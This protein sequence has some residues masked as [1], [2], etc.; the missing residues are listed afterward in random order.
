LASVAKPLV[1]L[2]RGRERGEKRIGV[3]PP[4]QRI[5]DPVRNVG[6][7]A[8]VVALQGLADDGIPTAHAD[9]SFR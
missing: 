8:H 9:V 3:N 2:A 7:Q 1:F 5:E 6:D 4:Q